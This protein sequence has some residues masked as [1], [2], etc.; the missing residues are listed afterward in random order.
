[1][2]LVR[3]QKRLETCPLNGNEE[4]KEKCYRRLVWKSTNKVAFLHNSTTIIIIIRLASLLLILLPLH[5]PHADM[6]CQALTCLMKQA[7]SMSFPPLPKPPC[8]KPPPKAYLPLPLPQHLHRRRGE[9]FG[10]FK[11]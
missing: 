4:L 5:K 11:T 8:H 9:R 3:N 1:M 2:A 10:G 6:T 7:S